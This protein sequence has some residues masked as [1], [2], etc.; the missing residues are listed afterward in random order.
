VSSSGDADFVFRKRGDVR[1]LRIA[2]VASSE[3]LG[4]ADGDETG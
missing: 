2:A 3:L 4:L 1:R